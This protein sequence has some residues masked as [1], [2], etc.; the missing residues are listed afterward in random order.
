MSDDRASGARGEPGAPH[1]TTEDLLER[2]AA[3]DRDA[4]E[5]L[6]DRIAGAVL[7]VARRVVIDP[8][9]AE[10]VAQEALVEVWQSA[11]RFDRDRGRASAWVLTVA[12]RRAVDRV[13]SAQ[14]ASERETRLARLDHAPAYDQVSEAVEARLEREQV[15][16]ALRSLT[17]LQR[18]SVRLAYYGG[19]T[20]REVAEHLGVPLGTVKARLRDGMIRL[21]DALGV[22]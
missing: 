7:G 2:V 4:F 20:H 9:Q 13:R 14:A 6:Y 18:E 8:A 22:A 5:R 21:R 12:H 15:H 1:E 16:Q 19:L 11:H 10:E 17:D 3:G